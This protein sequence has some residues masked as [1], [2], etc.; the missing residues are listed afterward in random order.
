VMLHATP[1]ELDMDMGL[2]APPLES[3]RDCA[4]WIGRAF[5]L[6]MEKTNSDCEPLGLSNTG[7]VARFT[8]AVL[9]QMIVGRVPSVANV[10][11]HLKSPYQKAGKPP[12]I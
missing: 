5:R 6:V 11:Q 4:P 7:P 10:G 12:V 9:Q 8:R 2:V 1:Y 3:W